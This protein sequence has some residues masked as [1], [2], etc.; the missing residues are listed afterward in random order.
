MKTMP[1]VDRLC[2]RC[3][4]SPRR[5]DHSYC[6]KCCTEYA[7]ERRHRI[8]AQDIKKME[9]EMKFRFLTEEVGKLQD[10][11][12]PEELEMNEPLR[13]VIKISRELQEAY[14]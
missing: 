9:M 3:G 4:K 5:S 1:A 12:S 10:I 6:N 14:V 8:R 7:K 13:N 2:A 11:V